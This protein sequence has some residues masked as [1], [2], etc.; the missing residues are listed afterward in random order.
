[1]ADRYRVSSA[2]PRRGGQTPG[3]GG[4][5]LTGAGPAITLGRARGGTRDHRDRDPD[6]G[7]RHRGSVSSLSSRRSRPSGGAPRAGRDR[8][9]RLRRERGSHRLHRLGRASGSSGLSHRRQRRDL[10]GGSARPGRGRRVPSLGRLAGDP[11]AR[12]IRARART[13]EGATGPR[14]PGRAADHARGPRHRAALRDVAARRHVF[15]PPVPGRSAEG[16]A[17]VRDARGAPRRPRADPARGDRARVPRRRRVRGAHAARHDRRR[18]A[19]PG[20]RRLVWSARCDAGSRDSDRP[21]ARPDVGDG[22]GD[23]E[24]LPDDLLGAVRARLARRSRPGAA[25]SDD[26]RGPARHAAS[27]RPAAAERRDHLRRRP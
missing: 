19:R 21:G 8:V 16:H 1:M 27:L 22:A 26:P 13:G 3:Q 25:L 23:A 5:I 18:R 7:W 6:R 24:H 9:R 12:A 15:A 4:L 11:H 14:P 17:G 2:R 20:R 10:R